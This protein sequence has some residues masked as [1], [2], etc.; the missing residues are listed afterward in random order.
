MKTYWMPHPYLSFHQ[1]LSLLE[2]G[3]SEGFISPFPKMT[4]QTIYGR[5]TLDHIPKLAYLAGLAITGIRCGALIQELETPFLPELQKMKKGM[6]PFVAHILLTGEG[7]SKEESSLS[8]GIELANHGFPVFIP[9]SIEE[10]IRFTLFARYLS[11]RALVPAVQI[12]DNYPTLQKVE[13]PSEKDILE[14]LGL[15]EDWIECP[16]KSQESL[17]GKKRRRVP[18]WFH[19]DAP[20]ALW[21]EKQ[22]KVRETSEK[23]YLAYI[24][25]ELQEIFSSSQKAFETRFG[26]LPLP[27]HSY[28]GV[29]AEYVV[30][31]SGKFFSPTKWICEKLRKE[32]KNV[33]V[34]G[35]TT[36]MASALEELRKTLVSKKGITFL[37][38]HFGQEEWGKVDQQVPSP[39]GQSF[40]RRIFSM[41]KDESK[42]GIYRALHFG[43]LSM[44]EGFQIFQNMWT[45]KKELYLL[46]SDF[47][48]HHSL[49]PKLQASKQANERQFPY[50]K[51][52][53]LP[54]REAPSF[55][56]EYAISIESASYDLKNMQEVLNLL[57]KG[58]VDGLCF[59]EEN[60]RLSLL[61]GEEA[62]LF[63]SLPTR[64]L[65]ASKVRMADIDFISSKGS[66]LLVTP[67]PRLT[68]EVVKKGQEKGI[69]LFHLS[70]SLSALDSKELA[71]LFL[72]LAE[73]EGT[74][75]NSKK[76]KK[77]LQCISASLEEWENWKAKISYLPW[78]EVSA[79]P[80]ER[81]YPE[82]LSPLYHSKG[83]LYR[84]PA[85]HF[86]HTLLPVLDGQLGELYP[87]P[88]STINALPPG[89][90]S[91]MDQTLRSSFYPRLDS[92]KCTGCT[93]CSVYCPSGS[94][95]SSINTIEDILKK[96][97]Q[98][99]SRMGSPIR[100]WVPHIKRVAKSASKRVREMD[101]IKGFST[102]LPQAFEEVLENLKLSEEERKEW[103]EEKNQILNFLTPLP[104]V[105]TEVHFQ[106]PES[107]QRGSGGLYALVLQ[108]WTCSGCSLCV[109]ICPENAL[110][111]IP[112]T[113]DE[114]DKA[115]ER[116]SRWARLD[117]TPGELILEKLAKKEIPSL[118]ALGL[119]RNF[120][121]ATSGCGKEGE[122]SSQIL[123]R[124]LT[125]VS[126][127]LYQGPLAK[128]VQEIQKIREKLESQ[129]QSTFQGLIKKEDYSQFLEY[130]RKNHHSHQKLQEFLEPLLQEG[131][132]VDVEPI[133]RKMSLVKELVELEELILKGYGGLGRARET[134]VFQKE[135]HGG[136]LEYPFHP[137]FQPLVYHG[138][139]DTAA[140]ALG[141]YQGL[142]HHFLDQIRLMRRAELESRNQYYPLED[143][144]KISALGWTDLTKEEK[145]RMA[146]LYLVTNLDE[147]GKDLSTF[148]EV[149]QKEMAVKILVLDH[150][151]SFQASPLRWIQQ[152][153]TLLLSALAYR[154]AFVAQASLG[155]LEFLYQTL[156]KGIHF[157]GPS[158]IR[159]F[160]F[161]P[162]ELGKIKEA[163][164]DA[165]KA[166]L[167]PQFSYMP[168]WEGYWG[169]GM[170]I[171]TNPAPEEVYIEIE[172]ADGRKAPFTL[173]QWA[174]KW[175]A[176]IS[177]FEK[178][179]EKKMSFSIKDILDQDFDIFQKA[180][181]VAITSHDGNHSFHP[182][183]ALLLAL[184]LSLEFWKI[185]QEISGT[186]NPFV[187]KVREEQKALLQEEHQKELE[188]KEKEWKEKLQKAEEEHIQKTFEQI[189]NKL[190]H[191]AGF[192]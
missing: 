70:S 3:L 115:K 109:Q 101:S 66:L 124:A 72:Y 158:L 71:F 75:W 146:P 174:L 42:G 63:S 21:L 157:P 24:Q 59:V 151:Q 108:P 111:M 33:G 184:R 56:K 45:E 171:H 17:F 64:A 35:I 55:Q 32:G 84:S 86:D 4:G 18:L 123:L 46:G 159:L 88:I 26:S 23:A 16:S 67:N 105:K 41:E 28:Y 73:K 1:S 130:F 7:K 164:L 154:K 54:L 180:E 58:A 177:C 12:V 99:V 190:L 121:L 173:L 189:K 47:Q 119:S 134:F 169:L 95:P 81:S 133:Q 114:V 112:W 93:L 87:H 51:E 155:D 10:A 153:Q 156:Q 100:K 50:L 91:L 137:F 22:G 89:T 176:F 188:Q 48:N 60:K 104:V 117:D 31:T 98:E 143:D 29:E 20:M 11:E 122:E 83:P 49:Y 187:S 120:Y 53:E 140:L 14:F 34:L 65:I 2:E 165:V 76:L 79:Q 103:E 6:V 39:K 191:L 118:G 92:Q 57:D 166:R 69:H 128:W 113:S 5:K 80:M 172:E 127:S 138:G 43:S 13:F 145:E 150:P 126:E 61:V 160:S 136:T 30:V 38:P 27:F 9:T 82:Y 141:A 78:N 44:Q 175:K 168:P 25:K 96:A 52:L 15:P 19:F 107:Y 148:M 106:K 132:V 68:Y 186:V 183:P 142:V 182:S 185:L 129:I 135:S 178:R 110:E 152:N 161:T 181:D 144:P 163:S 40:F 125:I 170:D 167:A 179:E 94:L 192:E 37:E 102:F 149:L 139:R 85:A 131:A 77:A 147:I 74:W 36:F 116:F 62:P 90:A 8:L 162:K 97:V